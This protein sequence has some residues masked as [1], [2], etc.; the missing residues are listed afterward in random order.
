MNTL[1]FKFATQ[2]KT[3]LRIHLHFYS[4]NFSKL[5]N[6]RKLK[7]VVYYRLDSSIIKNR[8]ISSNS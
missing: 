4:C 5:K 8:E 1:D 2:Q 6:Q 3:V 7:I